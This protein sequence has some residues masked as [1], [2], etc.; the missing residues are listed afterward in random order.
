[1]TVLYAHVLKDGATVGCAWSPPCRGVVGSIQPAGMKD[2]P[3]RLKFTIA[4]G[5]YKSGDK[6]GAPVFDLTRTADHRMSGWMGTWERAPVLT[7][8]DE[9]A[10]AP[11]KLPAWIRCPECRAEMM[12]HGERLGDAGMLATQT[13]ILPRQT[14]A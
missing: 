7:R 1:V 2:A 14:S 6:D 4:R 11:T 13:V 3:E 12:L 9:V 5:Y 8:R 10:F